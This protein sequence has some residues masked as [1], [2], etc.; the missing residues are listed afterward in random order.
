MNELGSVTDMKLPIGRPTAN[1]ASDR[2]VIVAVPE[3]LLESITTS[4]GIGLLPESK[5]TA[6]SALVNVKPGH[7]R[8]TATSGTNRLPSGI[9]VVTPSPQG[10]AGLAKA[11]PVTINDIARAAMKMTFIEGLLRFVT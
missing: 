2:N 3:A 5:N 11:D 6:V 7:V 9:I 10:L 8:V 1:S 4:L